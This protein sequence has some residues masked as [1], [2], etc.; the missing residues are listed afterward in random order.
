M[1]KFKATKKITGLSLFSFVFLLITSL[2]FITLGVSGIIKKLDIPL[3]Y[4]FL[5]GFFFLLLAILVYLQSLAWYTYYA[6]DNKKMIIRSVFQKGE[7]ELSN[8]EDIELLDQKTAIETV[9]AHFAHLANTE[10]VLGLRDRIRSTKKYGELLK[11]CTVQFSQISIKINETIEKHAQDFQPD[12][13]DFIL[14]KLKNGKRYILSPKEVTL[15]AEELKK[16]V[17]DNDKL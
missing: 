4:I 16:K 7:I 10:V 8:I 17:I 13:I 11:Y 5:F 15:F 12:E 1:Q 6:F 9:N 3:V 14:L 2:F